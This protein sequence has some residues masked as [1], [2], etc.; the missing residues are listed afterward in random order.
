[1]KLFGVAI[2]CA[3]IFT[4]II[5]MSGCVDPMIQQP[6]PFIEGEAVSPITG[7]LMLRKEV[8]SYNK[9]HPNNLKQADC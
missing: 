4:S 9:E 1:M 5:V 8:E 7:C 6:T 2:L 3:L